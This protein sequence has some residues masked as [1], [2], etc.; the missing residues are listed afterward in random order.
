[1]TGILVIGSGGH[2]KV[3]ADIL[4]SAGMPVGGFLDDDPARH[5]MQVAGLPVLG[6]IDTYARHQPAGLVLAIG[7]NRVRRQIAERLGAAADRLWHTAVHP[8][9][10]VAGSARLGRGVVVAAGAVINPD[11]AIGAHAIVNTGATVDHD[12]VVGRFAHLAPGVH[13]AGQ[14]AVG[15]GALIGVGGL[16]IPG[17]RIGAWAIVGAGAVVARDIPGGVVAKGV[18]ARW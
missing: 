17:R 10:V 2:G 16:V 8:R 14:V 12:A 5:G 6:A 1:M 11:A 18:P 9:A 3:V 15:D 13:L 4:L 7:A